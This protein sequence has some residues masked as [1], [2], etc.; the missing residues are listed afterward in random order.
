MLAILINSVFTLIFSKGEKTSEL[1][2]SESKGFT[3]HRWF[4]PVFKDKKLVFFFF[5]L[6]LFCSFLLESNHK[7]QLVVELNTATAITEAAK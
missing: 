2:K 6:N 5:F 1:I 7:L 3:I 4:I